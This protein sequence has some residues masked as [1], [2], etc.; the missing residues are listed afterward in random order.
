MLVKV[1][2]GIRVVVGWVGFRLVGY[3]NYWVSWV[4]WLGLLI[5]LT[6]ALHIIICSE[7]SDFCIPYPLE[8]VGAG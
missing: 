8:P 5:R 3:L 2:V 6:L 7:L 4:K 1:W